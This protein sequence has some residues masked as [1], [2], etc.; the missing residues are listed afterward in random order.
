MISGCE[1]LRIKTKENKD[2]EAT[3]NWNDKEEVK[4]CKLIKFKVGE[5]EYHVLKEDLITFLLILG[6]EAEMQKLIPIKLTRVKRY[7]TILEFKW[8][9]SR[10]VKKGEEIYIR[11]PHIVELPIN[12]DTAYAG[13]LKTK[14]EILGKSKL[15]EA[16]R[17]GTSN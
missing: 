2:W 11:A 13:V 16:Q 12:E 7:E 15:Y 17:R 9:A 6:S 14:K 3:V 5:S 1:T 4:D 8:K 10:D